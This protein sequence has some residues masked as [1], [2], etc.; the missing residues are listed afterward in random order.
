[1]LHSRYDNNK[2]QHLHERCLRLIY[3][4]RRTTRKGKSVSMHY[5]NLQNTAAEMFKIKNTI[6]PE[7]VPELF[8]Q[9]TDNFKIPPRLISPPPPPPSLIRKF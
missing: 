6:S 4:D 5:R 8:L 3:N 9:M 2:I 1:M 7:I